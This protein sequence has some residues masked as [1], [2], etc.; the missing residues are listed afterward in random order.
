MDALNERQLDHEIDANS[1]AIQQAIGA[2]T[3]LFR[4][5]FGALH[6]SRAVRAVYSRG[7]TPV[8]WAID[9]RDWASHSPEEVL[10]IFAQGSTRPRAEAS[11][12]FTTRS[13]APRA[14]CLQCSQRSPRVRRRAA[15]EGSS[16][17]SSSGSM[18]SGSPSEAGDDADVS[19]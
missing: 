7:M 6:N 3:F 18:S 1:Q 2:Q 5:P 4:A 14:P 16:R 19:Q 17:T 13:S 9:T 8:F 15:R 10:V 12:S 11:C